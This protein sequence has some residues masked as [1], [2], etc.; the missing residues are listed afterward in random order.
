MQERLAELQLALYE[1]QLLQPLDILIVG[2]TGSGKSSTI[3]AL[4]ASQ[5]AEVGEGVAPQTEKISSY[6]LNSALRFHDSAGLGDS[7]Q[8]DAQHGLRIKSKIDEFC[9]VQGNTSHL[10]YYLIDMVMVVLEGGKRDLGT[11]FTLLTD[12]VLKAIPPERVIVVINQADMIMKGRH[13]QHELNRPDITLEKQLNLSASSVQRRIY[14]ST[15]LNVAMPICYSA[16]FNYNLD[17]LLGHITSHLPAEQRCTS[18]A[19]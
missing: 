13:W 1:R 2:A 17:A 4:F 3:N 8:H 11:A 9:R 16:K 5:Q 6:Q 14:E 7:K 18:S 15:G 19:A 12:V 10:D